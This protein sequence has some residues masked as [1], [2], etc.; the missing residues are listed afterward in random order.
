MY[1]LDIDWVI[2]L[3]AWAVCAEL[4]LKLRSSLLTLKSEISEMIRLK[5]KKSGQA[6]LFPL[7]TPQSP[8][9]TQGLGQH[10]QLSHWALGGLLDQGWWAFLHCVC[11]PGGDAPLL[12]VSPTN[13]GGMVL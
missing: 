2:D 4:G 11:R 9:V 8:H 6:P 13:D 12:A 3:A 10:P 5:K 1:D 7:G